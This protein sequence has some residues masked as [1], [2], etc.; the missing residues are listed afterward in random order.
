MT[1]SPFAYAKR[2]LLQTSRPTAFVG[3]APVCKQRRFYNNNS[4][5][6]CHLQLQLSIPTAQDMED[7]GA[8]LSMDTSAGDVLCLQ[9][10]LGAGKTCLSRGFVQTRTRQHVHDDKVTSPTYLLT[11]TYPTH[12]GII[13][14]HMDLYRLSGKDDHQD[15]GPLDLEN[16]FT[17]GIA[18]I[19]WPLRLGTSSG[20]IPTER[21]DVSMTI[22]TN[23]EKSTTT[24]DDDEESVTRLVTLQAHGRRWTQRLQRLVD[25]GYVDDLLLIS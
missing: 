24:D 25:D 19:E 8:I 22:Q 1:F 10:D 9:G 3:I 12:D 2:I 16:V 5:L 7:L 6:H 11:N 21:L 20:L 14:H 15:L 23:D 4:C 13:I 18:L 17:N